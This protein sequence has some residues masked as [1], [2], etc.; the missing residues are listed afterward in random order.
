MAT[1]AFWRDYAIAIVIAM[2]A[3]LGIW[4]LAAL[5]SPDL[6]V[7]TMNDEN[8]KLEW[9]GPPLAIIFPYGIVATLVNWLLVRY[10]K[11][12]LWLYVITAI[13]LIGTGTQAFVQ[14]DGAETGIWLN[15]MHFAAT[16]VIVPT[17]ARYL[18]ER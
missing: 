9:Y 13:V 7:D 2:A 8:V 11:P 16:G 14:S 4:F 1:K 5:I 6:R 12:R 15:L 17:V 3:V 10:Q 18:P